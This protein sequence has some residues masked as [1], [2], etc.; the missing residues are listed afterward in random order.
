MT[1]IYRVHWCTFVGIVLYYTAIQ[2]L[3]WWLCHAVAVFWAAR[4]P[5]HSKKFNTSRKLKYL[6][7]TL[8]LAGL[9]LPMLPVLVVGLR[10][11]FTTTTSPPILCTGT[12]VHSTFW[13]IIFPM[14]I[15]LG[16]GTS[17]LI[18]TLHTVI[19]V[20]RIYVMVNCLHTLYIHESHCYDTISYRHTCCQ[21]F[22]N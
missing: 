8:V 7:I 12:D 15:M 11:S 21:K 20:R 19:K 18:C 10:G 1:C 16:T 6:H 13:V 2:L 17:T 5:L 3:F 4:W 22:I 9:L 14:S